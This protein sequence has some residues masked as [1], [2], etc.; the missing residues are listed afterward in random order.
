MLRGHAAPSNPLPGGAEGATT[1]GRGGGRD[2]VRSLM[3]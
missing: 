1:D 3:I 2:A